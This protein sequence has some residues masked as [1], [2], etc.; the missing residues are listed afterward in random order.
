[1]LAREL[2]RGGGGK[3]WS[4]EH[5]RGWARLTGERLAAEGLDRWA[6]VIEAPL[7]AHPL[8]PPGC[9]WYERRA[10]AELPDGGVDLLLVDGPP[11]GARGEERSRYPA[12]PELAPRLAAGALVVLDDAG[13]P[14]EAWTVDRWED[15]LPV[16]FDHRDEGIAAGALAFGP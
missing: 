7:A 9:R 16:T 5:D 10:L 14:G 11:A 6:T 15:L 8:A 13:R 3:L 1:V 2:A 12:L 4:L